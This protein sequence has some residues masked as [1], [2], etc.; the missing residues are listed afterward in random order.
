MPPLPPPRLLLEATAEAAVGRQA[1]SLSERMI[2]AAAGRKKPATRPGSGTNENLETNAAVKTAKRVM[3]DG[4]V[5]RERAAERPKRDKQVQAP[6]AQEA[7][8]AAH[9]VGSA[10][11]CAAEANGHHWS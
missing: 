3:E 8:A 7:F 5:V 10:V 4:Q 1:V 6:P 2:W 9:A 11:H